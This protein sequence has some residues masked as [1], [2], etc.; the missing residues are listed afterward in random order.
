[1]SAEPFGPDDDKVDP[2]VVDAIRKRIG[3]M[4]P[5]YFADAINR[6]TPEMQ[7]AAMQRVGQELGPEAEEIAR[8]FED[9]GEER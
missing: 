5:N 4:D 3:P 7:A 6:A 2:R 9:A 1:M 8:Q